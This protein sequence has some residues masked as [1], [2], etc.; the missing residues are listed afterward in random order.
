MQ[1]LILA[2][3]FAKSKNPLSRRSCVLS[4]AAAAAA[5]LVLKSARAQGDVWREYRP[6]DL[7][8]RIAMPGAPKLETEEDEFK[9]TWIK[10]ID[11]QIDYEQTTFGVNWTKW[12]DNQSIEFMATA[13]RE[14]MRAAGMPVTRETPLVMNGFSAREFIRQS[15]SLNYIHR[16]VVM[17]KETIK[18]GCPALC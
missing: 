6:A 11:A 17:G 4:L 7:G 14:G 8:F 5:V 13:L 18:G 9:D 10:S 12:K 3:D 15:D 16:E 2:T 1:R